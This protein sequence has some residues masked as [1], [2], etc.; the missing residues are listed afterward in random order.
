MKKPKKIIVTVVAVLIVVTSLGVLKIKA[1]IK[2]ATE[3]A[4]KNNKNEVVTVKE[5]KLGLKVSATGSIVPKDKNNPNYNNLILELE[6]DELDIA[7]IKK[8]QAVEIEVDALKGELLEGRV[9]EIADSAGTALQEEGSMPGAVTGAATGGVSSYIVKVSLPNQIIETAVVDT[10]NLTLRE[11]QGKKYLAITELKRDDKLEVIE[12][13]DDWYKV[14]TPD[15]KIGWAN[16]SNIKITGIKPD[17]NGVAS[18]NT[19]N[20][21][22][23]ASGSSDIKVKIIK[24]EQLQVLENDGNWYKVRLDEGIEG[25]VNKEDIKAS[26]LKAGMNASANIS[27]VEKDDALYLPI[28]GI[29]KK[30]DGKYYVK[31]LKASK[32]KSIEIGIRNEDYIEIKEG[33]NKGD[34]IEITKNKKS[35]DD[36][37]GPMNFDGDDNEEGKDEE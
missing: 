37:Q 22:E 28:K 36:K 14:K 34:K 27:I 16:K 17:S 33:L 5:G 29:V 24:G 31:P 35:K 8:D 23:K 20:V 4:E 6:V 3:E 25:W 2:K 13:D 9:T 10:D 30:D 11:G 21:R 15:Q 1:N 19:V 7:K 32:D 26:N 18:K 12:K